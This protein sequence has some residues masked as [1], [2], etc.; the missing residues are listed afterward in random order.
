MTT[1]LSSFPGLRPTKKMWLC[2]TLSCNR[3]FRLNWISAK[4]SHCPNKIFA[5]ECRPGWT[6]RFAKLLLCTSTISESDQ[7]GVRLMHWIYRKTSG[8]VKQDQDCRCEPRAQ[9]HGGQ[10]PS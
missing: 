4:G 9:L 3:G 8:G 6:R 2:Q 5:R 1:Q 10:A 7:F